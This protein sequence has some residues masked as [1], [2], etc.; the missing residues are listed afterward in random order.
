M[1]FRRFR[2]FILLGVLAASIGLTWMEQTMVRA[3]RAPLDVAIIPINGDGSEQ[4]AETIRALQVSDFDDIGAFLARETAR[5]G[6]KQQQAM[7]V[8]LLPE[9]KA[10]PPAP[11][12]ERSALETVWWSMQLRGWVYRQ[13]GQWLPQLG[14]VKLFVLFHAPQD[15]VA[16]EHSL[17]LQKGLIGVVHVFADPRQAGQNN[18]V[19]AHELLHTLGATDKYDAEGRPVYPQ[20][21]AAADLPQQ[22]PRHAAEI[23]AGRYVNAAGRLVMADSLE[24]CEIGAQTAHEINVD[25]GYRQR[26]ASSN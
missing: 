12:R 21:Y 20:G 15:G 11:S 8:T 23:M 2:I 26:Y 14:K 18:I 17:G 24:Q 13:S 1:T 19:I 4:A 25:E 3:W 5:Y 22:M 9:L 6:V 7:Q 16:L 10:H